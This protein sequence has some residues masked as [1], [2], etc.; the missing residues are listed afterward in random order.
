MFKFTFE[1]HKKLT[2]FDEFSTFE[3]VTT[4]FVHTTSQSKKIRCET[5]TFAR[6]VSFNL[7][8]HKFASETLLRLFNIVNHFNLLNSRFE[9]NVDYFKK[10]IKKKNNLKTTLRVDDFIYEMLQFKDETSL[11]SLFEEHEI[12]FEKAMNNTILIEYAHERINDERIMNKTTLIKYAQE[13]IND[14]KTVNS[15]DI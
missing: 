1:S 3:T 11:L 5:S 12:S 13:K 7:Q 2:A 4:N 9:Y 8:K 14:K 10:K 15:Q 6:I